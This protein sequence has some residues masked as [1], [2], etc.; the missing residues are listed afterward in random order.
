MTYL[1][2]KRKKRYP[3]QKQKPLYFCRLVSD[4]CLA[5]APLLE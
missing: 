4:E 2:F 3:V 1:Q 5:A